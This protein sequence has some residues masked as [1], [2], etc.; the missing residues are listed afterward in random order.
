MVTTEMSSPRSYSTSIDTIGLS[1]TV[2]LQNTRR[3][4]D[5]RQSDWNRRKRYMVAFR[6][7][8]QTNCLVLSGNSPLQT[9]TSTN[10]RTRRKAWFS[11]YKRRRFGGDISDLALMLR[12]IMDAILLT[13]KCT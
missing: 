10:C 5:D 2:W 9:R 1:C 4:T 12:L 13:D 11:R 8:M 6:L 7:K 3:Q